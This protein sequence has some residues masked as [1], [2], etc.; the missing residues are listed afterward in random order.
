MAFVLSN[1]KKRI[2]RKQVPPAA[3]I[4]PAPV[5]AALTD[6]AWSELT[7]L[8]EDARRK[9]VH[10][11]HVRTDNPAHKQP[12]SFTREGFWRHLE[13]VYRDVYPSVSTRSGSILLFGVVAKEKH[14]H[15]DKGPERAE[16]HHAACYASEKHYWKA[17]ARRS[18]E[19]G[20]KLHAAPHD[21]YSTMYTYIRHPTTKKPIA[22][23]DHSPWHSEDH[24]QGN[25]LAKLLEL[26]FQA[27]RWL[28]KRRRVSSSMDG[29]NLAEPA[30]RFRASDLYQLVCKA[31]LRTVAQLRLHAHQQAAV[32]KHGLAEFCTTHR[33][34][35]LAQFISGAWAVHDAPRAALLAVSD[36]VAKLRDAATWTCMCEGRW[37]GGV[38][39]IL[40]YHGENIGVFCKDMLTALTIG[41]ARGVNLAVV[42][43]PGCGKSTLFESLCL[44]YKTGAKPERDNSFALA[45]LLDAE[46]LLWQE[47]SW[48]KK[49]C[50]FEDLLQV[51]VGEEV[52]IR[53]PYAKPVKHSNKAPMFYTA[54]APLNMKS[55]DFAK[56]TCLNQAM[57]ERFKTRSWVRPLPTQGRM[58]KYPHCA[59]C[60]SKFVLENQP[61][62]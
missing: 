15:S 26:G 32:G 23:L 2:C 51:M 58:P 13:R 8:S 36:R 30:P 54:W 38:Q 17:V 60:F 1:A 35:E 49:M 40:N 33:E 6:E 41:A 39:F 19:L 12:D 43:P 62:A 24:P 37:A 28:Q 27:T 11:V 20:V 56:M 18:L 4:A 7:S 61:E 47:F 29:D 3:Y 52:G 45:G 31:E 53:V 10:W 50:A 46:V 57:T 42:G 22:E 9:H 59:C 16:H 5:L 14:A 25:E 48:D 34:D 44:I 21:G 55:H